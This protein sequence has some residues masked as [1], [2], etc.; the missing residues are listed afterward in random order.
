MSVLTNPRHERFAQELAKGKT[1][2]EAYVLVGYKENRHNAANLAR[3][4]HILTRVAEILEAAGTR[5]EISIAKVLRELG[6]L[7]FAD[8]RN[9]VRWRSNATMIG[10]DPDTDE[11]QFRSFN[12]VQIIGSHEIDDDTA[13]AIVEVSQTK[14]GSLR[15]KLADKR[16]ALV[17]IGRHLGMFVEK[18]EHTGADGG[19][20]QHED[21]GAKD[22]LLGRIGQLS[23]RSGTNGSTE[24]LN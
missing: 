5:A 17:D 9:A 19:P 11:P 12:E 21:V 3:K 13:A 6:K 1:A 22:A 24:K 8:I 15:I 23:A 14:E 20:I 18:H 2:D 4:Q 10:T 7:G 16:A